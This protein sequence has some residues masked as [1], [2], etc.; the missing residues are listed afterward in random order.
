MATSDKS[1]VG[2][3]VRPLASGRQADRLLVVP[4]RDERNPLGFQSSQ[5]P[6]ERLPEPEESRS[7]YV[8]EVG[9]TAPDGEDHVWLVPSGLIEQAQVADH[10]LASD[11]DFREVVAL[12]REGTGADM[13]FNRFPFDQPYQSLPFPLYEV[14]WAVAF[15]RASMQWEDGKV[16]HLPPY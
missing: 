7:W 4:G 10:L 14:A 13:E 15:Y 11:P 12:L 3:P 2:Q 9:L 16:P 5:G 6:N 1:G 8:W